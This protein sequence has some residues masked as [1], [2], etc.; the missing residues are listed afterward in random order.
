MNNMTAE[1]RLTLVMDDVRNE[2]LI[3]ARNDQDWSKH[4]AIVSGEWDER[5]ER[6]ARSRIKEYI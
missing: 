6:I 3:K 1:E 2:L 4:H 5:I